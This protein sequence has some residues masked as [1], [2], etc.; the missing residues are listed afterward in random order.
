MDKQQFLKLVDDNLSKKGKALDLSWDNIGVEGM[1]WLSQS[2]HL[3]SLQELY[4]WNN[5]IGSEGMKWLSESTHLSSL[6]ELYLGNNEIGDEGMRWLA[7]STHLSSLQML[8][9]GWNE[10]GAEGMKWLSKSAH[11]GSLQVLD[12]ENNEIG[13]EGMKWLSQSTHLS[14]LQ[15]LDLQW[16]GLED[17]TPL[18]TSPYLAVLSE[19]YCDE[20]VELPDA[21]YLTCV[22]WD[23]EAPLHHR[24][25]VLAR[26]CG[27]ERDLSIMPNIASLLVDSSHP[28]L[29]LWTLKL[30][31]AWDCGEHCIDA[32][33]RLQ[34]EDAFIEAIRQDVLSRGIEKMSVLKREAAELER[35]LFC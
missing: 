6:Q 19:L 13:I 9:L 3:N 24:T 31:Q 12:L 1:K 17:L 29:L 22:P 5:E 16:N 20:D 26:M 14:S 27:E 4:L 34:V 15:S 10:I 28:A 2:T 33:E 21:S 32:V 23:E 8:V 25:R 18:L 35:S 7:Q 11:L 30:L